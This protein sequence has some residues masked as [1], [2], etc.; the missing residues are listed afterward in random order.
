MRIVAPPLYQVTSPSPLTH[1]F[2]FQICN[3]KDARN[4]R[5]RF[6]YFQD[7]NVSLD[8]VLYTGDQ[9]GLF[10]LVILN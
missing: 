7:V 8:N 2:K 10:E 9:E 4:K 6:F 1:I 3:V 5:S